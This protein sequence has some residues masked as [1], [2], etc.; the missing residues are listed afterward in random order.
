KNSKTRGM[1][2]ELILGI[3]IKN[4]IPYFRIA[5][6]KFQMADGILANLQQTIRSPISR[7][8]DET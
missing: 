2:G 3:L 7:P 4:P 8:T 5:F 6:S 1:N